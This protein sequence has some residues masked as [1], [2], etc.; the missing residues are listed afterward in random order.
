MLRLLQRAR[1]QAGITQNQ[2]AAELGWVRSAVGKIER[3][4]RR[5]DV[6]ELRDY[7]WAIGLPLAK[8]IAQLEAE[9]AEDEIAARRSKTVSQANSISQAK[10]ISQTA[11]S[12]GRTL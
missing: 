7:C 6:I 12:R 4:E 1:K 2:V 5:I 9:L 8:F 11:R 3:G 10:P